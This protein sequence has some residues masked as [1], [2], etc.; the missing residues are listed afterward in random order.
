M[1]ASLVI[2]GSEILTGMR[3]DALIQPFASLMTSRGITMGEVR[4]QGDGPEL[5]ARTV[6]ELAREN[7]VIVVTGGLGL[8]PDDTTRLAVSELTARNGVRLFPEIENPVGSAKGI[9]LRFDHGARV[10]F[11]PGVPREAH[12][13]FRSLIDGLN[14]GAPATKEV[15]VFGLRE[16]EIAR[17][18]G[19]LAS[20]CG[21]LPREMEVTVIV[22]GEIED[23]VRRILA[24]FALE[25]E[26][27]NASVADLLKTRGL[28]L[29]TAESCTGGLIAHLVTQLP[30]S[31]EYF[32]GSVVSYS[33]GVKTGLLK[34]PEEVISRHGAVSRKTA[35]S[36]LKGI[37]DHT[38]ADLG[39]ATTGIAGPSG[40]S[41]GKPIGTVWIAAGQRDD[42]VAK[43]FRF[44][45][46]RQG[47]KM[48][49]AKTA[50]FLLR[51]YIHDTDIRGH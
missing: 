6:A 20:R 41:P 40:G 12:A 44:G 13:M 23:D 38:G 9:D 49:F 43:D 47:N 51:T 36:M 16:T 25:K 46:D 39:I 26:D 10:V 7:D 34:V 18:L 33:N 11:L 45:F 19:A 50:L 14:A 48:I 28:S 5:L 35:V 22:P 8:T 17:R 21:Y 3:S 2:T 31:S 1:K 42:L 32:L 29:A 24:P 4:I 27:L 30:G 15:A 37:L